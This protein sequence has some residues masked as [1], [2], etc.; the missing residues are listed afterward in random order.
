MEPE[1]DIGNLQWRKGTCPS[2]SIAVGI[3]AD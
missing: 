3:L 1:D 2:L